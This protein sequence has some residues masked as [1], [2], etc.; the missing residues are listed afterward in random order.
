[1]TNV[2]VSI[3]NVGSLRPQ[4]DL[5]GKLFTISKK[6][7]INLITTVTVSL[8]SH[9]DPSEVQDLIRQEREVYLETYRPSPSLSIS[10]YVCVYVYMYIYHVRKVQLRPKEELQFLLKKPERIT[11]GLE[12][13]FGFNFNKETLDVQRFDKKFSVL[14]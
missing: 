11:K 14:Y 9:T 10:I 6:H 4:L 8:V 7:F 3:V 5:L 12:V 1:M 13:I 2:I